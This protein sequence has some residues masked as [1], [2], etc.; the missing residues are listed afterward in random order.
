MRPLSNRYSKKY[1]MSFHLEKAS[2]IMP[3]CYSNCSTEKNYTCPKTLWL[4]T[5]EQKKLIYFKHLD[6]GLVKVSS[7]W[8]ENFKNILF[9]F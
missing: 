6:C 4:S 3:L 7:H 9:I 1:S 2:I 5:Y 8:L